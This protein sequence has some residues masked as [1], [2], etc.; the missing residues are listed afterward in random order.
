MSLALILMATSTVFAQRANTPAWE[1]KFTELFMASVLPADT[2]KAEAEA[3]KY[4]KMTPS[5]KKT[6]FK[7]NTVAVDSIPATTVEYYVS[8]NG[9]MHFIQD[10]KQLLRMRLLKLENIFPGD[11]NYIGKL[12]PMYEFK[13]L[14]DANQYDQNLIEGLDLDGDGSYDQLVLDPKTGDVVPDYGSATASNAPG[15]TP[16]AAAN[17][18]GIT[19]LPGGAVVG[20]GFI[21]TPQGQMM[22][23]QNG[24]WVPVAGAQAPATAQQAGGKMSPDSIDYW[25]QERT[26]ASGNK[27]FKRGSRT[28][29]EWDVQ[30]APV[31]DEIEIM[32]LKPNQVLVNKT[33]SEVML[34]ERKREKPKVRRLFDLE[35]NAPTEGSADAVRAMNGGSSWAPSGMMWSNAGWV[36]ANNGV[37]VDYS[38]NYNSSCPGFGPVQPGSSLWGFHNH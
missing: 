14:K 5:E 3:A 25:Y 20:P 19:T 9:R 12:F 29:G 18:Q 8:V 2:L 36:P 32:T 15:N 16:G 10:Q 6:Y 4:L 34:E 22:V 27:V 17:A 31:K 38:A 35:E 33:T 26:Y 23:Q 37:C 21:I 13:G 1:S 30:Q 11:K 28:N 7:A 24:S